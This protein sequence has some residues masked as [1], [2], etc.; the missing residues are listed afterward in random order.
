MVS[1]SGTRG[2]FHDNE[3][4]QEN[5]PLLQDVDSGAILSS[6]ES[7]HDHFQ[8]IPVAWAIVAQLFLLIIFEV[9]AFV[10]PVVKTG[11]AASTLSIL[12]YCHVI[13]WLLLFGLD[14]YLERQHRKFRRKGYL[15][16]Y[17]KTTYLR[18]AAPLIFAIGNT[19]LLVVIMLIQEYC[20]TTSSECPREAKLKRY[21]YV[22]IIG[23]IEVVIA[24]PLL[25][26]YLAKTMK[27]NRRQASPD[28]EQDDL[29]ASYMQGQVP[30]TDIGFRDVDRLDEVLEKQ[31]DLIRYLKQHNANLGKKIV[32]LTADLKTLQN[33]ELPRS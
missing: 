9:L 13:L 15:E 19:I 8:P 27:F 1:L 25:L 7:S 5:E 26:L 31:A 3:N 24:A 33:Q 30:C 32:K 10:L 14:R 21:N 4:S 17:H 23:T 29:T 22:Q 6:E 16:F 11:S 20:V 12:V 28:V 2:Q 18:K